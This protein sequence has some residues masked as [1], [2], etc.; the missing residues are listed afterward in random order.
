[1][2]T[3]DPWYELVTDPN[4]L[5]QGDLLEHCPIVRLVF[6]KETEEKHARI[7]EFDV[8]LLSQSCELAQARAESYMVCPYVTLTDFKK[9]LKDAG[10][11]LESIRN[12]EHDLGRGM[13]AG[14]LALNP[15][16]LPC[17]GMT[18]SL[19]VDF[20]NVFGVS[21]DL[22]ISVTTVATS[23]RLRL[24]PPYRE[25]LSQAFGQF[26]MKVALP[27]GYYSPIGN[28]TKPE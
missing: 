14:Y 27:V 26:V 23:G 3:E 19:V 10:A 28:Q 1:M 25:H 12:A 21:R 8:V 18:D 7:D 2:P 9:R 20:H 6:D 17:H 22:L 16:I 24:R 13:R 4:D 11:K 15:C 5:M